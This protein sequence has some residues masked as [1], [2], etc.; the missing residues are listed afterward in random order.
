[1]RYMNVSVMEEY[2]GLTLVLKNN[3]IRKLVITEMNN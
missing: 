1:M 2:M 3:V